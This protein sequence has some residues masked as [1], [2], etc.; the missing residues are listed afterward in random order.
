MKLRIRLISTNAEVNNLTDKDGTDRS[1]SAD[2]ELAII[3]NTV[4]IAKAQMTRTS[5]WYD[6][7]VKVPTLWNA[8]P[9]INQYQL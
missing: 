5:D 2:N 1:Y 8:V 4:Y 9:M 6:D 7:I 3:D